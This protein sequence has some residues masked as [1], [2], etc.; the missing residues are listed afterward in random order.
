MHGCVC[1]SLSTFQILYNCMRRKMS[2]SKSF[3]FVEIIINVR[4]VV[5]RQHFPQCST[6]SL[7]HDVILHMRPPPIK[8][9]KSLHFSN[10]KKTR[11][12]KQ[13]K[14]MFRFSIQYFPVL[15]RTSLLP[16]FQEWNF[17]YCM[18]LQFFIMIIYFYVIYLPPASIISTWKMIKK[19]K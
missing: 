5:T 2:F 4:F 15:F 18:D 3:F 11:K 14:T 6:L 12:R 13:L 7:Y 8:T 17:F 1:E 16:L 10:Q 19:M 9:W